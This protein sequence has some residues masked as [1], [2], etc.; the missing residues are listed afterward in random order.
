MTAQ[1]SMPYTDP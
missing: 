1:L